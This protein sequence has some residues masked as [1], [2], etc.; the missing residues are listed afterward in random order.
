MAREQVC[1]GESL[2]V[3]PSRES[4]AR[5]AGAKISNSAR[6][7]V[8]I[9]GDWELPEECPRGKGGQ[10]KKGEWQVSRARRILPNVGDE[11][12]NVSPTVLLSS[13]PR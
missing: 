11:Q 4:E 2:R 1:G 13:E 8:F 12:L 5:F 6:S 9:D 7:R 3:Q 10:G